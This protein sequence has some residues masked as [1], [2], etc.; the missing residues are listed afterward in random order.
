MNAGFPV[1]R[2][3]LFEAGGGRGHSARE[4]VLCTLH[5]AG[6]RDLTGEERRDRN[7]IRGIK[8]GGRRTARDHRFTRDAGGGKALLVGLEEARSTAG[9]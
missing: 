2:D 7:F 3:H 8:H 5:D 1:H 6:E 9:G 4:Y